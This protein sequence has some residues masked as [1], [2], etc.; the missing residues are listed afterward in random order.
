MARPALEIYIAKVTAVFSKEI[1]SLNF[2]FIKLLLEQ[3]LYSTFLYKG[4]QNDFK[5]F[6][7]HLKNKTLLAIWKNKL[8]QL[9]TK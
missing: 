9:C 1:P 4:S 6:S 8:I 7:T 5:G 3:L 2:R